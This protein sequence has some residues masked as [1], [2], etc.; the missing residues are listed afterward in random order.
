MACKCKS[1]R[2]LSINAKCS[3]QCF[4]SFGELEHEGYVPIINGLGGGDY[5][6]IKICVDCG[7][8]QGFEP[9]T[10]NQIKAAF[11]GECQ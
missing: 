4:A 3:D 6:R 8:L 11:K 1:T 7:L 9:L 10:N 2:I 5:L